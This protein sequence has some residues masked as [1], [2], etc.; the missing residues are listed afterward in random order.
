[1]TFYTFA[2][3]VLLTV[4]PLATAALTALLGKGAQYALHAVSGIKNKNLQSGLDWAINQLQ[5]LARDAVIAANQTL[6]SNLKASGKWDATAASETF[7][8]VRAQVE[9]N[10][11]ADA[12]NILKQNMADLNSFM[13]SVIEK[14]V[15]LAPNKTPASAKVRTT[16]TTAG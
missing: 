16:T 12:K 14:E 8:A 11:S 3:D 1:M 4:A 13:A 2:R 5:W 15:A 9:A 10:L 6:V 7:R